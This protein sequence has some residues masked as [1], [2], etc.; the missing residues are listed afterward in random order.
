[1]LVTTKLPFVSRVR[2]DAV[3][4]RQKYPAPLGVKVLGV[5]MF[6][7]LGVS[8]TGLSPVFTLADGKDSLDEFSVIALLP[9]M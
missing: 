3:L 2:A 9:F 1:M 4:I 8:N 6:E 7:N 5:E